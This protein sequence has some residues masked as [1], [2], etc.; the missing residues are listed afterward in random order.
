[1]TRPLFAKLRG[2]FALTA[3]I[4]DAITKLCVQRASFA[5]REVIIRQGEAYQAI[6]LIDSGW[7]LRARHLRQGTRQ[8]VNVA[9]AGDFICFNASLFG[10]SDFDLVA[11]SPVAA[12]RFER[13]GVGELFARHPSLALAL[14]WSNAQEESVLAERIVSLGRRNAL[15]RMAHVLCELGERLAVVE[16]ASDGRLSLPLTQEDL[17]DL[18][19]M[20]QIHVNRTLRALAGRHLVHYKA[21]QL[22]ILDPKGLAIAAGFDAGYLHY[23]RRSDIVSG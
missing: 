2:F 10:T 1:M 21:G 7:V 9:I 3:E 20:S 17:A 8:I 22:D 23:A 5:P 15:E 19:G 12:F 18:L 13:L 4:E 6:Y 16:L 14:A 11:R